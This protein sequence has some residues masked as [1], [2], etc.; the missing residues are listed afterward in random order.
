MILYHMRTARTRN[1]YKKIKHAFLSPFSRL[2]LLHQRPTLSSLLLLLHSPFPMLWIPSVVEVK[3]VII[4]KGL[5][6]NSVVFFTLSWT[7]VRA[8]SMDPSVHDFVIS[9]RRFRLRVRYWDDRIAI[10]RRLSLSRIAY[11]CP[12]RGALCGRRLAR[13]SLARPNAEQLW[14]GFWC[15]W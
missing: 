7:L 4:R 12:A 9:I 13:R 10:K 5:F 15:T 3:P 14:F 2:P 11:V 6:G 8:S 1:K